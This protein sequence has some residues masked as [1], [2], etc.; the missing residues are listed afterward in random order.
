MIRP[1]AASSRC[2]TD[3]LAKDA[4]DT[5]IGNYSG[6]DTAN[7]FLTHHE[8]YCIQCGLKPLFVFKARKYGYRELLSL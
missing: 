1:A 4:V 3:R 7:V 6:S 5:C 8:I 2:N